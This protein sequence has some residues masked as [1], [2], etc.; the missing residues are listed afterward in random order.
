VSGW[1]IRDCVSRCFVKG[2]FRI[3]LSIHGSDFPGSEIGCFEPG[4]VFQAKCTIKLSGTKERKMAVPSADLVFDGQDDYIEIPNDIQFSLASTGQLSI[5]VWIRPD[6]LTFPIFQSTGYVHWLGKGEAGQHE[7]AFRMYNQS[8]TDKPPRPNRISFYVFNAAGGEGIGSYFQ[9]PVQA[10]NWIHVVGTADGETSSIYK[11]GE[12]KDCD[13][14]TGTGPGPCHNY[15]PARWITPTHGTAPLRIGTRDL[16]S[17]FLGA[18][19]EVRIWSR[20]LTAPEIEAL[21]GGTVPPD[22][23]VAEYLLG[24]DVAFDNTRKHHG[25]IV[26]A[27][28]VLS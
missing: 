11:N 2:S 5:S 25:V 15:P 28:W 24:Q 7:W 27:T 6:V 12:F 4:N 10:G 16:K 14:Y 17:F 26:G 18:I 21:Y 23:L 9:E 8:T 22:G 1:L 20:A 19:R 13:R 3:V